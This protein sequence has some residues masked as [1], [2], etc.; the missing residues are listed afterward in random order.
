LAVAEHLAARGAPVV[1]P[2]REVPSGPHHWHELTLTLWKY[3]EPVPGAAVV[4]AE[5]A[6]ALKIVHEGL[7][8]LH[9]ELPVFDLELD[10]DRRLLQPQRSPTLEPADRRFLLAVVSE[11]QAALAGSRDRGPAA[12]RKPARRKLAPGRARSHA[13]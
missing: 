11:L 5:I 2:T 4:P 3:I 7:A 1:P 10:D 8:D 9:R 12:A 6:A 13:A